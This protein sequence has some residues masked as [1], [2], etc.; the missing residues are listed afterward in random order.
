MMRRAKKFLRMTGPERL[1]ALRRWM[2]RPPSL[3]VGWLGAALGR[4]NRFVHLSYLPDS[5]PEFGGFREFRRL[6][7]WWTHNSAGVNGGDLPRLLFLIQNAKR[8]LDEDVSGDFAELGV[9]KGNSARVLR[10][11]LEQTD[12]SRRLHLFD[13]FGG[14]DSRDLS[15]VDAGAPTTMFSDTSLESVRHFVGGD[16]VC[17]Y[18]PGYFPESAS[19][20]DPATSFALVHLDCDLYEPTRAGLEFF[21]PRLSPGALV[22]IHDYSSPDWPGTTE[23]VDKFLAD[24]PERLVLL[25]DHH[26]SAVFRREGNPNG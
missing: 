13:T 2:K 23:A 1:A 26:G 18:R 24:K 20:I 5:I 4:S 25:P 15:G 19:S 10:D 16:G 6:V 12:P 9:Y 22:V 17:I 14:F 7:G 8:V 21:Y 11:A 3:L